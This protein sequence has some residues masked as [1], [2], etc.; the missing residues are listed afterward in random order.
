[1]S[2]TNVDAVDTEN[3]VDATAEQPAT[4]DTESVDW[5]YKFEGQQK[6][7]RDLERKFRE[8]AD[9]AV[10]AKELK[11]E[12]EALKATAEGREKE[13]AA[14]I[15]RQRAKD[16]ALAVANQ[17]ILSAEL[18]AAAKGKLADPA[19]AS[20]FINLGDFEVSDAGDV[21]TDALT[22]AIDDLISRK[23][24]LAA[25]KPRRFEGDA[26]AGQK[27]GIKA[28]QITSREELSRMTPEQVAEAD[29]AGRLDTLL[30]R[31]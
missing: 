10:Q 15:E 7:N 25:G 12:L 5:K 29:A 28:A 23:P 16:E 13:H 6:V 2:E 30:G 24:H 14:D 22:A 20:L 9:A 3:A 8:A 4:G 18:K 19:D 17:R 21:D 31:G 11:A 1:M 27:A 26:D